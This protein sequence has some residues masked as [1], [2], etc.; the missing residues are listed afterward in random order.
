MGNPVGPQARREYLA[1]MRER[2]VLAKNKAA[3]SR[4]V[5]EVCEVTGYHRKVDLIRFGGQLI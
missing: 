1:R 4:L 3:K 2:Y 5:D